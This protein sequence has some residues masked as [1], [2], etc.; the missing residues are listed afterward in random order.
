MPRSYRPEEE[1][2]SEPLPFALLAS[3]FSLS[4]LLAAFLS[5]APPL[6]LLAMVSSLER[7]ADGHTLTNSACRFNCL[8]RRRLHHRS[9]PRKKREA[10]ALPGP[11]TRGTFSR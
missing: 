8:T 5:F 11:L 10:Q 3:R 7:A 1:D 2:L 9:T 6:S 4:V